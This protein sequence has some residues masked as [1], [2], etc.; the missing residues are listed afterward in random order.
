MTYVLHTQQLLKGSQRVSFKENS[1]LD[2]HR[3]SGTKT[4]LSKENRDVEVV[5][6]KSE[7]QSSNH[8]KESRVQEEL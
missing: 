2:R 6:I 1:R 5:S 3:R 8:L 4:K 7:D